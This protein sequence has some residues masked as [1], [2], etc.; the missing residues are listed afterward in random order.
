MSETILISNGLLLNQIT[1]SDVEDLAAA[2]GS[3]EV[4]DNV[5]MVPHPYSLSD[6]VSWVRYVE[7]QKQQF[8]ELLNWCIRKE[9]KL[10]GG[11]G[12][13]D[14]VT[15]PHRREMGYWLAVEHWGQ[16]IMTKTIATFAEFANRERGITR[17][18]A[19]VY[20]TNIGSQKVLERN[21]FV[22]EGTLAKAYLKDG[23]YKDAFL[24]A[25]IW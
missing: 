9:G 17:L 19:P 1:E 2:I 15:Q 3:R 22:K 24:Y 5:L 7:K 20:A 6:A 11:I 10:I 13:H 18:E 25:R 23:E 12:F 21:G 8:G 14:P 16:G 4:Y